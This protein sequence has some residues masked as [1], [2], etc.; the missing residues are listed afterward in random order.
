VAVGASGGDGELARPGARLPGDGA[1][2]RG[3]PRPAEGIGARPPSI[4]IAAAGAPSG[5]ADPPVTGRVA[6]A[7]SIP[8]AA[9]AWLGEGRPLAGAERLPNTSLNSERYAERF[10]SLSRMG[11]NIPDFVF[12]PSVRPV[13]DCAILT[14]ISA[15]RCDEES[16]A[17]ICPLFAA[18]P[19]ICGSKGMTATGSTSSA[20]AKSAALISGR[21]G[22][23]A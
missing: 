23:P 12:L 6:G 5:R 16:S 7:G 11:L 9:G 19:K 20:L 13:I 4:T 2:T 1:V 18:V 10:I 14:N 17:I 8:A 22:T 15:A 21:L 3:A